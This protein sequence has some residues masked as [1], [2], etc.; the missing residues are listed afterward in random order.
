MMRSR[1]G[2]TLITEGGRQARFS[3]G[4]SELDGTLVRWRKIVVAEIKSTRADQYLSRLPDLG[5]GPSFE[6]F[7][8]N[9]RKVAAGPRFV[10]GRGRFPPAI[11][12]NLLV[13]KTLEF[14]PRREVQASKL[15]RLY[16]DPF[17]RGQ[18][19]C[20]RCGVP[21]ILQIQIDSSEPQEIG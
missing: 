6:K 17:R 13:F 18:R 2:R 5:D 20:I 21:W 4:T 12:S 3:E 15:V 19:E 14:V 1:F 11:L 8:A 10:A 16:L 9:R 7:Y